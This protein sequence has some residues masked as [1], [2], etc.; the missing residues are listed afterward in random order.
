MS[1]HHVA[2]LEEFA[3]SE[4]IEIEVG[5]R[6][7]AVYCVEGA[8]F[9]I[10]NICTH[11]FALLSDGYIDGG[12]VECP[13][14]QALFDIRTGKVLEGPTDKN[15]ETYEVKLEDGSVSVRIPE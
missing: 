7:V 2:T 12:C 11:Q 8:Y 13:L 3:N 1:W 6:R 10:D 15:L 5:E 4:V 14:H 9:A